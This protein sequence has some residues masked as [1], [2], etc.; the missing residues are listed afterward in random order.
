MSFDDYLSAKEI[1]ALTGKTWRSNQQRELE[2]MHILHAVRIDGS[3]A[4]LREHVEMY[5][6]RRQSVTT[7][8]SSKKSLTPNWEA[9]NA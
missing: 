4:V 6:L 1:K 7:K 2:H 9:I 3:I 5:L 8:S